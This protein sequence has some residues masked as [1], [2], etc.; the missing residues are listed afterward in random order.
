MTVRETDTRALQ[1]ELEVSIDADPATVWATLTEDTDAWWL[2]DFHVVAA[3]S[4]VTLDARAGGLLVEQQKGGG[5]L[6]WYQVQ[7][8]APGESLHLVGHLS[9]D[10]G[11]P[12]TTMLSI[13]LEERDG[14]TT[15]RVRDALF[16]VVGEGTAKSLESG[17]KQL[18]GEGLA[19]C[20]EAKRG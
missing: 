14:G 12:A 19:R 7:H 15:L 20:A 5:S 11:G 4:V 9:P 10:W 1:Y 18:F 3:D 13:T 6:N 17:W 2:P 16:G 8:C